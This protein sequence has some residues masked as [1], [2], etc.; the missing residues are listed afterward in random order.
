MYKNIVIADDEPITRMDL[1]EM[2][3][4]AG[5]SVVGEASDGFDA[6]EL[7]RKL[8]PDL[9]LMDVKM[10]LLDGL[11]ASKVITQEGL[12]KSVVLLTA[13]SGR[14]FI[15]QAKEAGVMGYII[16]PIDEKSLMPAIEVALCKGKE[17]EQMKKDI[18]FIREQLET[19][20][21][22]EKAKGILMKKYQISEE[23]AY[24]R[25]RK[26]SMDKRCAMKQIAS[27]IVINQ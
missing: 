19:R 14:E 17:I 21:T 27:T 1:A 11:K 15:E 9:V 20:K 25:I 16:K 10:P 22:V 23:E 4:E 18:E 8:R 6:V 26:L 12:A 3:K 5:Y 24:K 2:L 7:C 13:Y